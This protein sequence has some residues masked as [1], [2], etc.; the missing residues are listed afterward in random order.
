V[1]ASNA[2]AMGTARAKLPAVSASGRAEPLPRTEYAPQATPAASMSAAPPNEGVTQP[3]SRR[4][5]TPSA[6][7]AAPATC[8]GSR[9]SPALGPHAII[10]ICTAPKRRSA[11]AAVESVT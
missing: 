3:G 8:A 6:A 1:T 10:V 7:V 4:I 2:T 5:S 9:R 11:P